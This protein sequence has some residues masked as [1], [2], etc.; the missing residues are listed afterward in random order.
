VIKKPGKSKKIDSGKCPTC[1]R[2][3]AHVPLR[4]D[5]KCIDEFLHHG[6]CQDC[7]DGKVRKIDAI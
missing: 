4:N 6:T 7:Q 1:G 3:S 2:D 5:G